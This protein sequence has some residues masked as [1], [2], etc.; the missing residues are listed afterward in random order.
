MNDRPAPKK[1]RNGVGLLQKGEDEIS[2]GVFGVGKEVGLAGTKH[3]STFNTPSQGQRIPWDCSRS[4]RINIL[5]TQ[6]CN[7]SGLLGNRH[8]HHIVPGNEIFQETGSH[9]FVYPLRQQARASQVEEY[10]D[11]RSLPLLSQD[12]E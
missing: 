10:S 2:D 6:Y 7:V 3:N 5:C 1:G 12:K 11:W 4:V 9:S 8:S